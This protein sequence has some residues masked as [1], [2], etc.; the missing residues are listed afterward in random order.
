MLQ[1]LAEDG[2]NRRVESKIK[3]TNGKLSAHPINTWRSRQYKAIRLWVSVQKWLYINRMQGANG[4]R[5]NIVYDC[6][7]SR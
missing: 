7:Y 3:K 5:A 4:N 1:L 6:L 2:N